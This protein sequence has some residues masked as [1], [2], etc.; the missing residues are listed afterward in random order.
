MLANAAKLCARR[1][2]EG[3]APNVAGRAGVEREMRGDDQGGGGD[4]VRVCMW[5]DSVMAYACKS[6][7][8]SVYVVCICDGVCVQECV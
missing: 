5:C 7:C 6:A 3:N 2:S 4:S 1:T 8:D